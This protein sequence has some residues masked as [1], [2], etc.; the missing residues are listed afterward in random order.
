MWVRLGQVR[1]DRV[2]TRH[3]PVMRVEAAKGAFDLQA[4][5]HHDAVHINR[6][7][8][9]AQGRQHAR[10][11]GRVDRLQGRDR[12]HR[13]SLQPPTRGARRRHHLHFAEPLEQRIVLD[14]GEVPQP[15]ATDH[16]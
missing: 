7:R 2:V 12:R 5:R 11:H 6:P 8:P 13:E 16:Q 1:H 14:E 4:G 9:H 3:L 15:S 10:D